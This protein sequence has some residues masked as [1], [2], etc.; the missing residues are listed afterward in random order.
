MTAGERPHVWL[1]PKDNSQPLDAVYIIPAEFALRALSK[2]NQSTIVE[3]PGAAT[4]LHVRTADFGD[5]KLLIGLQADIADR[6]IERV[7]YAV[8]LSRSGG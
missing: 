3:G 8:A 4:R 5:Q 6:W 1:L 7:I 2:P